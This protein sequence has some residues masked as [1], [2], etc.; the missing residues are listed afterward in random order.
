M[1]IEATTTLGSAGTIFAES[2]EE[3]IRHNVAEGVIFGRIR[4][5][6]I[7]ER[8]YLGYVIKTEDIGRRNNSLEFAI[9]YINTDNAMIFY[10]LY[11][12]GLA[13]MDYD[14]AGL[15]RIETYGDFID[16]T[17]KVDGEAGYVGR[18][19][20]S[21]VIGEVL[22]IGIA[23][24]EA[25]GTIHD[26]SVYHGAKVEEIIKIEVHFI[27][28]SFREI[29][30]SCIGNNGSAKVFPVGMSVFKFSIAI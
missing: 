11:T 26:V 21:R 6:E 22:I 9:L 4:R 25:V 14:V 17:F 7:K 24:G 1:Y 12:D 5:T 16:K 30:S 3:K 13:V 27:R 18:L 29:F 8:G 2:R 28:A 10:A 19:F 15:Y 23:E 20:G